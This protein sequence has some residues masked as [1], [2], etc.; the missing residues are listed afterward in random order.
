[1]NISKI[2]ES[3]IN[4]SQSLKLLTSATKM[5]FSYQ[6]N[7]FDEKWIPYDN[8]KCKRLY[9][10]PWP[11]ANSQTNNKAQYPCSKFVGIIIVCSIRS[12]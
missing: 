1:M 3:E 9:M 11:Q 7:T 8:P 12:R 2:I 5:L 10:K 4:L 6:M